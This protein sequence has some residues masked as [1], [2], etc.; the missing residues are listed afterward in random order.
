MADPNNEVVIEEEEVHTPVENQEG[1]PAQLDPLEMSDEEILAMTNAP[2]AVAEPVEEPKV[3]TPPTPVETP[4]DNESG[5]GKTD[6]VTETNEEPKTE[7]TPAE[8]GETPK[9]TPKADEAPDYK[10]FWDQIMGAP[11]KAN[12]KELQLKT[13]DEAITLIKMG[14]NYTKKMQTLQPVLRVVKML[15]NNGL[16]DE[17]KLS[18]L[19]D[20]DKGNP[21]AIQKFLSDKK[22]DPQ[23]FDE[24]NAASYVP[25]NHQVTDQEMQFDA[26]LDDLQVDSAGQ[27]LIAAVARQWDE[28]SRQAVYKEPSLLR[29]IHEQKA[30]GLYDVITT[31][32]DRL[33]A[34]GQLNGIP[35]LQAYKAVGDMMND[36]GRLV[37]PK[38]N[39]PPP[40]QTPPATQQPVATRVVTSAPKVTNN[41]RAK[42]VATPK[43]APAQPKIQTNLLDLPDDE[44]MKSMNGR[45]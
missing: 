2:T 19:I 31:E 1:T 44:F 20:L 30:N 6:Q 5:E 33:T 39:T 11:L 7:N 12:G 4:T 14:A 13:P 16:L 27:E 32:M 29:V 26:V 41:E 42:A 18:H 15:E 43:A 34:L 28:Q 25:G 9:E 45:L 37:P 22:F 38:G 10:A 8:A 24:E 17:S 21:Q 36:Q 35:F 23:A 3:E 40:M